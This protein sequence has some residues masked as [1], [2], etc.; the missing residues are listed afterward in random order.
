M[1]FGGEKQGEAGE[2]W[3]CKQEPGTHVEVVGVVDGDPGLE[4][5]GVGA[6]RDVPGHAL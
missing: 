3:V 4:V 5:E 2:E 1:V 6:P